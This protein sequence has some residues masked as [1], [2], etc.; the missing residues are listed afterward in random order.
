LNRIHCHFVLDTESLTTKSHSVLDPESIPSNVIPCLTRN[1]LPPMS[2]RTWCG[3]YLCNRC[4]SRCNRDSG[5]QCSWN[6]TVLVTGYGSAWQTKAVILRAAGAKNLFCLTTRSFVPKKSG[7]RMTFSFKVIADLIRNLFPTI[8]IAGFDPQSLSYN[9]SWNKPAL[10]TGQGSG[11]LF[12]IVIPC[13]TRNLFSSKVIPHLMRNLF[14]IR[15]WN[16]FRMTF[17][18]P[19][20]RAWP[21]I[22][23]WIRCWQKF[24]ILKQACPDEIGVREGIKSRY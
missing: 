17:H 3:I 9:R 13:L 8:V 1:P 15:S 24:E 20:L 23:L 22:Y 10:A 18:H 19:S 11:W 5:R 4:W 6:K 7:I 16:E 21:A 2:F 14:Y 12:F